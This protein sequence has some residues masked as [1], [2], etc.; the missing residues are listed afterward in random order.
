VRYAAGDYGA[1]IDVCLLTLAMDAR[2]LAPRRLLGA[3]YLQAGQPQ[4]A[5][6]AFEDALTYADGDVVA[7]AWLAHARAV[8]GDRAAAAGLLTKVERLARQRFVP[9]YHLA[10]AHV[11]LGDHEAAFA[12]LARATDDRDP[13]L[14]HVAVDPRFA[15]L[16]VDRRYAELVNLLGI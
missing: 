3:A 10:M 8:I 9:S 15:P 16:K 12:A 11:G 14:P 6:R 1:A 4:Q 7:I 13:A 5:I 2:Y